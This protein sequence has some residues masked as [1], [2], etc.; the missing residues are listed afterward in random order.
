MST[1][2]GKKEEGKREDREERKP[3]REEEEGG[4]KNPG[5]PGVHEHGQEPSTLLHPEHLRV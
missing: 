1:R 3:G 4:E 5:P 2:K